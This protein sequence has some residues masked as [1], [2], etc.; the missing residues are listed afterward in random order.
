MKIP[1]REFNSKNKSKIEQKELMFEFEMDLIEKD[2]YDYF[3]ACLFQ[4]NV[5]DHNFLPERALFSLPIKF[6]NP[7]F[8]YAEKEKIPS[9]KALETIL[10]KVVNL[11]D[12][13]QF[14]PQRD[15]EYDN[16]SRRLHRVV[17]WMC[18]GSEKEARRVIEENSDEL[19]HMINEAIRMGK[20]FK[21]KKVA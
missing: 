8:N 2:A 3:K 5:S 4:K 11:L 12:I 17:T 7:I 9:Y 10:T 13:L 15:K 19:N 21:N 1:K 6:V 18:D 16:Q 20:I 14:L